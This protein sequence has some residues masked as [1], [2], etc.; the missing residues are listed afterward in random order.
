MTGRLEGKRAIVTGGDSGIGRAVAIAFAR[1]GAD[2]AIVYFEDDASA[3]ETRQ[4]VEALGRKCVAIKADVGI[5]EDVARIYREAIGGLGGLEILVNNAAVEHRSKWEELGLD[6]WNRVLQT[7]LTGY[8]LMIREALRG[9]HLKEGG[10]IIN[11]GSI[12]G[13]EG[14]PSDPAY[15]TTKGGIHAMTKSLAS[16]L[17]E[18]KILVNCVAPGPVDTPML[19]SQTPQL[20]EKQGG[21]KY[22]LGVAQPEQIAPS[23]VFFASEDGSYFTGEILA[24]TGGKVT[25]G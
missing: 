15:S 20:L 19:R 11:T 5:E 16:Y 2:V 14:S 9:G 23:Y 22:P 25:A 13:L 24:P 17:V 7:N 21:K 3:A 1:E 8:F 6:T 4:A 12:Q 10:R 18:R